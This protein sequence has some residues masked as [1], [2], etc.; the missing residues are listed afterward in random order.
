MAKY[1]W[2]VIGFFVLVA[3]KS[4]TIQVTA[5]PTA[6]TASVQP[7]DTAVPIPTP[8]LNMPPT[9]V[10][11]TDALIAAIQASLPP[12]AYDGLHVFPLNVPDGERPLW[13]IHSVGFRN[14]DVEPLPSHFLAIYTVEN[15]DWLELARQNLDSDADEFFASP[16]ILPE[17]GVSQVNIEPTDIWL[18]VDGGVGAHSGTYQLLRFDGA[19]IHIEASASNSSPGVGSLGDLND[20]DIPELILDQHDYYVFCYACGVRYLNFHVL[21]WDE[22][23]QRMIDVNFQ[24]L[25]QQDHPAYPLNNRAIELAQA[26]LWADALT[27]IEAAQNVAS[28]LS[29]DDSQTLTWNAALIRLNHDAWLSELAQ[30]PYPLLTN[31]FF[32]DYA[33]ALDIMRVYPPDQIF[34]PATPLIA[35]TMAESSQQWMTDYILGQANPAIAAQPDLAA[36]YYLRAWATF[37]QNPANPLIQSDL[38]QAA[39]LDP[40]EPLFVGT[41]VS[42]PNRIQFNPGATSAEI[43]AQFAADGID[44]YVLGASAGQLMTVDLFSQ[45]ENARLEVHDA[46]GGWLDGQ[47]TTTLWQGEL[48]QT[49]DYVVRL[50]G[51]AYADYT[52][53]VSIP[54]RIQFAPGAISAQIQGDLNAHERDDYILRAQAGQTMTVVINSPNDDVLLTIVGLDGIPLVNGLMSGATSWTG[55]LPATQDYVV[56]ALGTFNAAAYTL[57]VTIE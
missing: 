14:F 35:G 19:S 50:Y 4:P 38:D 51:S 13:V 11:N 56:R 43:N 27:Q 47:I 46:N 1:S 5:V 2:F 23:A 49:A 48:P 16:D 40:T 33:G 31:I 29:P 24:P 26:G 30:S 53:I 57:D 15:G 7:T 6:T 9:A 10:P 12:D 41:A 17:G 32:G 22:S 34:N 44:V 52:L 36:A 45:D 28:G 25:A 55:Q 8:T 18:A 37:L 3:C 42:P 39:A 54:A 20:D 21:T